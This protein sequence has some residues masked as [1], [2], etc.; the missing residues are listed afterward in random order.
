MNT[1]ELCA[2]K[3]VSNGGP[4]NAELFSL[5]VSEPGPGVVVGVGVDRLGLAISS[6]DRFLFI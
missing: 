3:L 4:K 1:S 5:G 2:S 6:L